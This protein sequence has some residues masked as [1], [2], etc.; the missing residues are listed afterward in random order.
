MDVTLHEHIDSI[1]ILLKDGT[2]DLTKSGISFVRVTVCYLLQS[3]K[4][5]SEIIS[6]LKEFVFKIFVVDAYRKE[7]LNN[8]IILTHH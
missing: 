5:F 1:I 4:I 6:L 7:F 2:L 3:G 8:K